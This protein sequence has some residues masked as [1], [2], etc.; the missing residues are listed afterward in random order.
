MERT[1]LRG[2]DPPRSEAAMPASSARPTL[3][4][5]ALIGLAIGGIPFALAP[6]TGAAQ[7]FT[8]DDVMSA[9]FPDGLVAARDVDLVAWISNDR[10]RR[11]V[12]IARGPLYAGRPV[13]DWTD[14]DG[15]ELTDLE[16]APDGSYLVVRR[17]GAPNRQGWS[18]TPAQDV[19]GAERRTLRIELAEN[20]ASSPIEVQ[21]GVLS[22]DGSLVARVE[23]GR[24]VVAP[25][26][27][28]VDDEDGT[29]IARPRGGAGQLTWSPDGTRIAFVS[30]RGDHDFVGV[31]AVDGSGFRWLAPSVTRDTDPVWSPDGREIAFLRRWAGEPSLPFFAEP[32]SAIPWQVVVADV[33]SETARTVFSADPG[34]GSRFSTI[35][36]PAQLLWTAD[37]HL[38]FPWE[39]DGWRRLWAVP[40]AG[41][42]P[43]LLT[44]GE[45]EIQHMRMGPDG[46]RIVFDSNRDDIDRKH[47]W[48]VAATDAAPTSHT[49][50]VG[51]EWAPV[52][53]A[54]G[55]VAFLGSGARMAA[56]PWVVSGEA[57]VAPQG[58]LPASFPEAQLV[59][60]E[61]V[62]FSATDGL[63]IHG[64]L[65][66]PSDLAAG[67]RRP[68]VLFFHGGSRR[69]ML[70]GFHNRGYYHNAYAFNQYLASLGYVVL[71][72]NYRSGVGYGLDFREAKD[73]G[74]DGASEVRDVIG[75]ALYLRAR[76][77]VDPDALGL[78]GGSY[79]GYLTAQGLVHAPELFAAGVDLHGVHDW[80]VGI[81]NFRPDYEPENQPELAA[82]AYA[83]S[84]MSR[85]DRWEDPVLLI[86]GDDDRNVRFSETVDLARALRQQGVPHE[87]LVFPDEV[88][89]FLLHRNWLRAYGAA[90]EHFDRWLRGR[91]PVSD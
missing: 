62:V 49:P 88:H 31:A 10:G 40:A 81:Q 27:D 38:V 29:P 91:R 55:H 9:P 65:F 45:H 4:R 86:H 44:P 14:D 84:P 61:A 82:R 7:G 22:P 87:V 69:Q 67:E 23:G 78:W 41:G 76:G 80:N 50:G 57:R 64:Q 90:A 16:I 20:A 1:M 42:T 83:S 15:Q 63:P 3:R 26:P 66:L 74:A 34:A 46:R 75:A 33:D 18:P 72:V 71:A 8:L 32:E 36:G 19:D 39:K 52:L 48:S 73:Y 89:G 6:A 68:A 17:G 28:G 5:L 59:T 70:L 2:F 53:T 11:N 56:R 58:D 35:V 24:I 47:V 13:T 21:W 51:V 30:S 12:W 77:D 79:G 25:T 37:G 85:L 54:S 60:P 43:R